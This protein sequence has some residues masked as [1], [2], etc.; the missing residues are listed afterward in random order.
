MDMDNLGSISVSISS[1]QE[2]SNDVTSVVAN[3]VESPWL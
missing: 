2:I 3:T 1:F